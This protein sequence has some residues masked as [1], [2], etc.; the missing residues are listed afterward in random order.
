MP[1]PKAI[2]RQIKDSG[3]DPKKAYSQSDI[4]PNGKIKKVALGDVTISAIEEVEKSDPSSSK[5]KPKAKHGFKKT[6]K[7][8]KIEKDE[9]SSI[10]E[11]SDTATGEKLSVKIDQDQLSEKTV[12]DG[13]TSDPS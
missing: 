12:I 13:I 7:S 8:E 6:V 1:S 3:L 10:E 2:L 5:E 4:G 11:D 9:K